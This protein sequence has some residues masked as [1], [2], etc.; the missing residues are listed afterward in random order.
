MTVYIGE[1]DYTYGALG[2]G[3]ADIKQHHVQWV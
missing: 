3:F 1:D 2:P